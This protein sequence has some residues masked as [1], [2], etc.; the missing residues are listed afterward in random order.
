MWGAIPAFLGWIADTAVPSL[1]HAVVIVINDVETTIG[2]GE[3]RRICRSLRAGARSA[4]G[5]L[6]G[7][8]AALVLAEAM[9]RGLHDPRMSRLV[10]REDGA[11]RALVLALEAS[12]RA[13]RDGEAQLLRVARAASE[14]ASSSRAD[15]G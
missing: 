3:A 1:R 13:L 5:P 9:S 10:I 2:N 8:A 6:A 14:E 12:P 11:I 7:S 15:G 4:V